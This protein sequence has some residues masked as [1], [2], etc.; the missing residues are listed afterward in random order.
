MT[1]TTWLSIILSVVALS[2]AKPTDGSFTLGFRPCDPAKDGTECHA[3][4]QF[5][6]TCGELYPCARGLYCKKRWIF[7]IV[8]SRETLKASGKAVSL[9]RRFFLAEK[10]VYGI[11]NVPL[12]S[13]WAKKSVGAYFW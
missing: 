11:A 10:N 7:Y 3:V 9:K 6:Q 8:Y 4:G 13:Q 5:G 12:L 2:S 1:I